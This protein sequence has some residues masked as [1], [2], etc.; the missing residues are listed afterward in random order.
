MKTVDESKKDSVS[1]C[2][3][4][5]LVWNSQESGTGRWVCSNCG[6]P[7]NKRER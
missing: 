2:C 5:E 3:G 4:K 1:L 6:L 7:C